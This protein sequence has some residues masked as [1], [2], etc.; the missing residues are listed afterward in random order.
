MRVTARVSEY[1][2]ETLMTRTLSSQGLHHDPLLW[3]I[4]VASVSHLLTAEGTLMGTGDV[5]SG[6][7]CCPRQCREKVIELGRLFVIF[8]CLQ[9]ACTHDLGLHA[10]FILFQPTLTVTYSVKTDHWHTSGSHLTRSSISVRH[11]DS[12]S[13]G[14]TASRWSCPCCSLLSQ[15]PSISTVPSFAPKA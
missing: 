9:A 5:T 7:D 3:L 13:L 8:S 6:E 14:R 10:L 11:H 1:V 12:R 4:N 2:V 15:R